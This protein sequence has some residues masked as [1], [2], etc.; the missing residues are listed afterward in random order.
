[1]K[2]QEMLKNIIN[3]FGKN[4]SPLLF[5]F[6]DRKLVLETDMCHKMKSNEF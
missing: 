3:V 4:R 6:R 2:M 1:M 5:A